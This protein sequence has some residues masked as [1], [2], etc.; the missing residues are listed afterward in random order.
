M[1]AQASDFL[2]VGSGV[3]G[4]LYALRAAEAGTVIVVTKK[5]YGES[6]T[7]YAQ[8]GVASVL[9]DDDTYALHIRDTL[10]AGAGL[11][12]EEAVRIMVEEGPSRVRHLMELGAKF[13]R[14]QDGSGLALGREGGHSR[15]RIVHAVDKTGHEIEAALMEQVA[16]HPNVK[17]FENH[18]MIDIMLESRMDSGKSRPR[19][20]DRCWGAFVMDANT[21]KIASFGAKVVLMATGGC[22]KVYLYTSNPDIATGD[23]VA[24]AYRAGAR[25]ANLE[26]IQF[27]PTCLY[28]P[29]AKSFLISEAV[30]GEGAVLTRCDGTEFMNKYH[31]MGCLAPRDIVARAIDAEMKKTG[32]KHVLLDMTRLGKLKIESR[33]PNIYE[34]CREFGLDPAC[35]PLPVVPAA[36]YM[37]GGVVTDLMGRTDITGL[38]ACG[39]TAWTGV[40]GANRLASNSLLEALVY[41]TRA[42]EYAVKELPKW[43]AVPDIPDWETRGARKPRETV[44]IDHT[45]DTVRR[46]MWDYVGIVR[47]E[48]RLETARR[49]LEV[50]REEIEGYYV[51]FLLDSDLVELRNI[52]QLGELIV[53][54]AL[55]RKESRG[56]HYLREYPRRDDAN[57]RRDTLV[58][59][60]RGMQRAY[61]GRLLND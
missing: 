61:P 60:V 15:R 24:A 7:N 39:E 56:L 19:S 52:A 28:H 17:V 51:A 49:R 54:C 11:C 8:G 26:F 48:E 35:E 5:R 31:K 20:K 12:H 44:A 21:G 13:S 38:L 29:E 2:I 6:N 53:A 10:R 27:H 37:C 42:A 46:V 25:I 36:H 41:S 4:L 50:L 45:W 18:I 55:T 57:W 14:S 33:F 22:G 58:R 23:G 59:K 32:D 9:G 40:H 3:A 30:R 43:P 34:K 47:T 16:A 1:S